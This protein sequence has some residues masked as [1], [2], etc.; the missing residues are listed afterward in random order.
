MN[1]RLI[2]EE[3]DAARILLARMFITILNI[4][5]CTELSFQLLNGLSI[6]LKIPW[7]KQLFFQRYHTPFH[8]NNVQ[9][10]L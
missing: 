8:I 9:N 5:L 1:R 4:E 6:V 3:A 7:T 2:C 10:T